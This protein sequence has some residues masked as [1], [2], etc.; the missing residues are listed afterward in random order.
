M[1][2]SNLALLITV[3][4]RFDNINRDRIKQCILNAMALGYKLKKLNQ[5]AKKV[6]IFEN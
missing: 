6:L 3:G 2:D 5:R 4:T 1:V